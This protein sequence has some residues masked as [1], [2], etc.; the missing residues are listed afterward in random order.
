[1]KKVLK[2]INKIY[3]KTHELVLILIMSINNTDDTNFKRMCFGMIEG[4]EIIS[5]DDITKIIDNEMSGCDLNNVSTINTNFIILKNNMCELLSI[6]NILFYENKY[7]NA[8]EYYKK[9]LDK[10]TS[11]KINC[12]VINNI[13]ICELK[14]QKYD[15]SIVMFRHCVKKYTCVYSLFNLSIAY[16]VSKDFE[17][18]VKYMRIL[19]KK[20][21]NEASKILLKY[22]N[23]VFSNNIDH[24][25]LI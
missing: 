1:M 24:D 25:A 6:G 15:E 14:L 21:F 16:Y 4:R 5:V 13:A 10:N 2:Y 20:G 23:H 8:I 9:A 17:Q 3:R 11:I 22:Y 7:D 19:D 12:F 18:F